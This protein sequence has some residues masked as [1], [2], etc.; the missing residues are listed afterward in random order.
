MQEVSTNNF[1][2]RP[3]LAYQL[4]PYPA[5]GG[6]QQ[7][8]S[9]DEQ[10]SALRRQKRSAGQRTWSPVTKANLPS[11]QAKGASGILGGGD[12]THQGTVTQ[13]NVAYPGNSK[14]PLCSC[15]RDQGGPRQRRRAC[16]ALSPA[17]EHRLQPETEEK[18]RV[19]GHGCS[20]EL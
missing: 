19:S 9:W 1:H 12:G 16:K 15:L 14:K 17:G 4:A 5:N 13:G 3:Q 6:I 11:K 10:W 18:A 2:P 8:H 20:T 7:M